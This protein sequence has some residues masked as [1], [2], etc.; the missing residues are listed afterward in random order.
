MT[1]VLRSLDSMRSTGF[2]VDDVREWP[3]NALGTL[4]NA[5]ILRK[6][7]YAASV[8]CREC[9]ENCSVVVEVE[10]REDDVL[11]PIAFYDCPLRDDVGRIR[12]PLERL[13]TWALSRSGLA[14][15]L[16]NELQTEAEP[17]E[18]TPGRLWLLGSL[19][20]DGMRTRVLLACGMSRLD[21]DKALC[22][23]RSRSIL[24]A[25]VLVPKT[26]GFDTAPG[27]STEV[28]PLELVIS[29]GP[30]GMAVDVSAISDAVARLQTARTAA[31]PA[32]FLFKCGV[33]TWAITYD[34]A[35]VAPPLKDAKGLHYI[36]FLLAHPNE[37]HFALQV[38]HEVDGTPYE[39][40][41]TYSAMSLDE[42]AEHSLRVSGF[43]DAGEVMD[44]LYE[45][46]CRDRLK[47]AQ[48]DLKRAE[49]RN[50]SALVRKAKTEIDQYRRALNEAIGL[51][52]RHRTTGDP[53]ENARV[54]VT[55]AISRVLKK[56]EAQHCALYEHLSACLET[57]KKCSYKP[58]APVDW[59]F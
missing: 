37:E 55:Q 48:E 27:E 43:T 19:V 15:T 30:D 41:E 50:D 26:V 25:V 33:D 56:L 3:G 17:Q 49:A 31:R 14:A 35:E 16:A 34:G 13:E 5:G 11:P 8:L 18:I 53:A 47:R 7:R 2:G 28:V 51:N 4:V 45:Q 23:A 22:D 40:D 39:P 42:L 52:G 24:P 1:T 38:I 32:D 21:G 10:D 36:A 44:P 6:S 9:S 57:G 46:D 12:I 20:A 29:L 54:A 59:V 58:A